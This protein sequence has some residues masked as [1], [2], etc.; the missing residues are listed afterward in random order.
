M[1]LIG[2]G[3][4]ARSGKDT[5]V[6]IAMQILSNNG[7]T[8]K[9][10]PFAAGVK[11]DLDDWLKEKY[12]ISAWTTDDKE[13]ILI[14]PFLVAHGCGKRI[15]TDGKYWV[16]K[17]HLQ[18]LEQLARQET[19]QYQDQVDVAF[20]SDVRFPNEANWLHEKWS[21][22]LIHLKRYT[23]RNTGYS[24]NGVD[25]A[26]NRME[27]YFDLAPNDEELKND[28]F[29]VEAADQRVEWENKG[30]LDPLQAEGHP[31][32]REIV[33]NALNRTKAFSGKLSL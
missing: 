8:S 32:L 5:F 16:D 28:P 10:Y 23:L 19:D 27:P 14:R 26:S 22:D 31:Y 15:Q 7:F 29:I 18:L 3:G 1:K 6:S 24:V 17:V 4:Y 33:F 20:V 12:G 21:G 2:I 11:D 13:K 25:S 30:N 9:K